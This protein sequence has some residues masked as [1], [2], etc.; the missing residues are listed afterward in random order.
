MHVCPCLIT[1]RVKARH[2]L[3]IVEAVPNDATRWRLNLELN[4]KNKGA[5]V[6]ASVADITQY[7][8]V[9]RSVCCLVFK[10]NNVLPTEYLF[11]MIVRA[12]WMTDLSYSRLVPQNDLIKCSVL[13]VVSGPE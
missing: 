8:K 11:E 12:G 3:R 6:T 5:M 10:Y 1:F 13:N 7:S 2:G 9:D 4:H